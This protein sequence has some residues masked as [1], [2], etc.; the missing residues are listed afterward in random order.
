[1]ALT[2]SG[3]AHL[4]S[5]MAGTD[6]M[7][8]S[9]QIA[10]NQQLP[11]FH[12]NLDPD[13]LARARI[14]VIRP[15][16]NYHPGVNPLFDEAIEQIRTAGAEVVDNLTLTRYE[17]FNADS[18]NVLLYEFKKTLNDYLAAL[19][20]KNLSKLTLAKLIRYNQQNAETELRWFG[21]EIFEKAQATGSLEDDEYL[22]ALARVQKATRDGL[23]TLMDEH[24]LDALITVTNGP[25]WLIDLVNGD[26][27][28]GG[29][30]GFPAISGYPHVTQP[31]GQLEGLPIGLSWM[32]RNYSDAQ[33]I[34]LAYAYEQ[35][36]R[37]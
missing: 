1:M 15:T 27:Y 31:M 6:P 10:L 20:D 25:A 8:P 37:P 13:A 21:Q 14:G 7:D 28:T 4:L 17:S 5:A 24:K 12:E 18:Y 3:A 23:D 30:S 9:T 26:S 36:T 16:S 2:V 22:K 29:S 34:N 11:K 32:G 19:P 35:L 33:L